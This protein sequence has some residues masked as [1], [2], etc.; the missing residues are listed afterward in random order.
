MCINIRVMETQAITRQQ[1]AEELVEFL[2]SAFF[3]ALAEP[4]RIDILK[5]LFLQGRSDIGTIAANMPQDRSVISRHLH[6][7]EQA[8]IVQS[9]KEGRHV[10]YRVNANNFSSRMQEI[11][12]K[13][14]TC[15]EICYP[16]CCD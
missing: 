5:F 4:V 14:N 6:L 11:T 2:D 3:K 10:Y 15:V 16:N 13:L 12:E 9:E 7:M 1:I 8:G